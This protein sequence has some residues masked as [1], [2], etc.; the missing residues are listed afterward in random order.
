MAIKINPKH[1]GKLHEDLGIPADKPIPMS[2]MLAAKKSSDP[3]ERKRAN[4]AV[5]AS[6][7]N[8]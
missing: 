4:F 3:A 2:R 8:K 5:N 7:W 1:K 6:K